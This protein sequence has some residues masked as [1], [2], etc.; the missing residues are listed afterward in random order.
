MFAVEV[1]V[2]DGNPRLPNWEC[3]LSSE[4][5]D[6]N[7]SLLTFTILLSLCPNMASSSTVSSDDLIAPYEIVFSCSLCQK[8]IT[9]LYPK[10]RSEKGLNH[11]S[12]DSENV[13]TKLWMTE[14]THI[15]CGEHFEG[16]GECT[17]LSYSMCSTDDSQVYPFIQ[18]TNGRRQHVQCAW[19]RRAIS[20][21]GSSLAS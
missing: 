10:P 7:I 21:T 15:T 1:E 14:C 13:A 11:G 3:T 12:D 9:D 20:P 8:T 18:S 19:Q 2:H 17:R 16:G 4:V 6:L 5:V